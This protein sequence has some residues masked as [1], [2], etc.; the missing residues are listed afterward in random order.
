MTALSVGT[1]WLLRRGGKPGLPAWSRWVPVALLC[2]LA[3]LRR[4]MG[5]YD[6]CTLA[7]Y[8]RIW[9]R[10]RRWSALLAYV[11]FRRDLGLPLAPRDVPLLTQ[12]LG[13]LSPSPRRLALGLLAEA[14]CPPAGQ[15]ADLAGSA[16]QASIRAMQAVWRA[17]FADWLLQR[18]ASGV[19]VVG[20]A[21][22]LIGSALGEEIDRQGAVV[23]FNQFT[24]GSTS[25]A[26]IGTRIDVWVTAP[27]FAGPVPA[28]VQWVVVSGPEMAFRLQ[29]W[30]RFE[31]SRHWG[32]KVLTVP[33]QPWSNLV[34]RLDAP[35]SAG[36]L[37]LAWAR[38]LLGSWLPIRAV[39]FGSAMVEGM[40]YHQA[41]PH[42]Q[43][44]RRHN[45]PAERLVLRAWQVEGLRFGCFSRLG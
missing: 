34:R 18:S 28:G 39:G 31:A 19:C 43:P 6:A 24:G 10:G 4:A 32:A 40:P 21:G 41:A 36:L 30:S 12:A 2:G 5:L 23:R 44:S 17:D 20:N 35:P 38:S 16:I 13:H 11:M 45:W 33:L 9:V 15:F 22:S 42:R 27:G 26:D 1:G 7:L 37:F 25:L 8:R 14:G 29:D 3:K